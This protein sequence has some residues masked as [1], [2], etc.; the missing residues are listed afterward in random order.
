MFNLFRR[1]AP[2]IT[3]GPV[4]RRPS[5]T[6]LKPGQEAWLRQNVKAFGP[7]RDQFLASDAHR[8]QVEAALVPVRVIAEGTSAEVLAA[9]GAEPNVTQ[10][11]KRKRQ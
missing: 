4:A 11:R 6:V 10:I 5:D 2:A 3:K 9:I 7:C 1:T 8:R